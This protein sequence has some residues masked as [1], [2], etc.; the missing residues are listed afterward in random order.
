M[1]LSSQTVLLFAL[2]LQPASAKPEKHY[3]AAESHDDGGLL[4]RIV[5]PFLRPFDRAIAFV[6][7]L[8]NGETSSANFVDDLLNTGPF[9]LWFGA[10][11]DR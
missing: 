5:Q 9:L 8:A 6:T 11:L 3:R 4:H 7:G 10:L 2:L 1:K